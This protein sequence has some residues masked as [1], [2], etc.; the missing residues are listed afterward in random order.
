MD[1]KTRKKKRKTSIRLLS[2]ESWIK[3]A[4]HEWG[5]YVPLYDS[6]KW[7][8]SNVHL[9]WTKSLQRWE[10]EREQEQES[11]RAR[12]REKQRIL[13][14]LDQLS[15]SDPFTLWHTTLVVKEPSESEDSFFWVPI[16]KSSSHKHFLD[17]GSLVLL[18]AGFLLFTLRSLGWQNRRMT[19]ENPIP[20]T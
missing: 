10:S 4:R 14:V 12:E 20:H 6:G 11:E 13:F 8:K 3:T 19:D 18:G 2:G 16:I 17:T 1:Y 9:S 7:I 5:L 15:L